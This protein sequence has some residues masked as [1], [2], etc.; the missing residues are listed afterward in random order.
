MTQNA[1]DPKIDIRCNPLQPDC[2]YVAVKRVGVQTAW[3]SA[4][5]AYPLI[6]GIDIRVDV[7]R[8]D[9]PGR[10]SLGSSGNDGY[11]LL[12]PTYLIQQPTRPLVL[13]HPG[14][15]RPIPPHQSKAMSQHPSSPPQY[16]PSHDSWTCF[17]TTTPA[18]LPSVVKTSAALAIPS[19]ERLPQKQARKY[20]SPSVIRFPS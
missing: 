4:A 18:T 6:V 1:I 5:S 15:P 19:N 17:C 11:N 7:R 9:G 16:P 13:H 14:N 10:E 12:L 20:P 8:T 2:A 3:R